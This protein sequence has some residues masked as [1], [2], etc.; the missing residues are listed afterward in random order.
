MSSL[1]VDGL[2]TD[3]IDTAKH[4][5]WQDLGVSESQAPATPAPDVEARHR[6]EVEASYRSGLEE[7]RRE[8]IARGRRDIA[9][10]LDALGEAT[11]ELRTALEPRLDAVQED[12]LAIALAVARKVVG[13]E[14]V[15]D[16]DAYGALVRE[17]LSRFPV[18]QP[19]RVR[20]HPSDLASIATPGP[21]GTAVDIEGERT[22][23]WIPDPGLKPGDCLVE[24]AQRVVDGTIDRVLERIYHELTDE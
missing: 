9:P 6:E 10:A 8:G 7:G 19:V 11:R 4:W 21:D 16:F 15:G 22:V 24:G 3:P 14:L 2:M 23:R 1:W 17:A 18:D 12:V 20:L 13:R 5:E